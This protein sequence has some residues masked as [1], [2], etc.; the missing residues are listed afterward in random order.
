MRKGPNPKL[1][2]MMALAAFVL[3]GGL[4]YMAFSNLGSTQENLRKLQSESKDA[5]GLQA[6]LATSVASLQESATKLQHLEQ[7]VQD[8]A[9]VP[10]LL[11]E[12]EKV[13][14]AS[15]INVIGVRPVPKAPTVK[16]DGSGDGTPTKRKAYDEL[17][18]EVKGRG[19]YRS[20]MNFIQ[21]LGKFPKIVASRTVELSPKNDPTLPTSSLDVTINLRAYVFATPQAPE[22]KTA[23]AAGGTHEG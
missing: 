8:Y 13:G 17:D 9:Y 4:T 11:S 6:E 10:T 15:G 21:A 1:F 14:K 2:L 16:K 22:K 7:G 3:G 5:K 23:M 12:L 19:N 18:I 20:V